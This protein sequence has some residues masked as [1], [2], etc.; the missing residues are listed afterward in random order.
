MLH[1]QD[2]CENI[3]RL[4]LVAVSE[5]AENRIQEYFKKYRHRLED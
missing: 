2:E 5:A 1:L 3:L 4:P